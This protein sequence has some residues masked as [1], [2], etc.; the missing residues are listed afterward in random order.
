MYILY[1]SRSIPTRAYPTSVISHPI[2]SHPKSIPT[3]GQFLPIYSHPWSIL[4]L[5]NSMFFYPRRVCVRGHL[6][7]I[8]IGV[9]MFKGIEWG[10]N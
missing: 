5:S 9:L 7:N 2:I 10:G 1:D 6:L 4:I 3:L 8:E